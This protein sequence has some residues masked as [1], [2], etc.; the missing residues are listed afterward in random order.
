MNLVDKLLKMDVTPFTERETRE[1]E[2]KRLS[3][4]FG[5]PF[6]V[7][8]GAIDTERFIELSSEALDKSGKVD[9]SK[10]YNIS[11]L[12]VCEGII[13]PDL[14]NKDLQAHFKASTPKELAKTLFKGD[15]SKISSVITELSGFG[16]ED[17]DEEIKN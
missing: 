11:A 6:I 1:I 7:T 14:K 9:Y 13:S 2:I 15:I 5:E 12:L 16:G 17:E 4:K 3:D 8:V 10:S